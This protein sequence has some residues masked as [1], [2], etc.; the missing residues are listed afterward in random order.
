MSSNAEAY[1][2]LYDNVVTIMFIY[3]KILD[4]SFNQLTGTLPPTLSLI[5]SLEKIYFDDNQISGEIPDLS[6]LTKMVHMYLG[7]NLLSGLLPQSVWG[8]SNL[9]T[10]SVFDNV[11]LGGTIPESVAGDYRLTPAM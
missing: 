7:W 5:T 2:I 3:V 4:I 11:D 8:L 9:V 6:R 10:L 1:K